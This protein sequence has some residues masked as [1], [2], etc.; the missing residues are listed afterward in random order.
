MADAI[1][2]IL[3]EPGRAEEM[4]QA[5]RRRIQ[6]VFRWSDAAAQLVDVFEE[7]QRAAHSRPRAA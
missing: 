3:G 7:V 6:T 4:G 2:K 1:C 5:A